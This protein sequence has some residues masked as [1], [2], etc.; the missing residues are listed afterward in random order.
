M[1]GDTPKDCAILQNESKIKAALDPN[2]K[3]SLPQAFHSVK[4]QIHKVLVKGIST[5]IK[6]EEF[7]NVLTQNK[8]TFAKAERF[9]SKRNGMSFPMFL[10]DCYHDQGT[11]C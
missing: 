10:V 9:I 4:K 6:Q 3:V 1:V 5:D 7:E 8:T 2:V 11:N